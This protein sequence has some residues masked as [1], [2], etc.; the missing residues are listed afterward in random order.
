MSEQ[1]TDNAADS[2][3][4]ENASNTNTAAQS[5]PK[6]HVLLASASP[7]RR[8]LLKA[9]GVKFRVLLP[10]NGTDEQLEPD[11]IAMPIE[12]AKKLA[13]RKAAAA[14]QELLAANPA[15]DLYAVI[16]ADTM[17][18]HNNEI[19][20]K[21]RNLD[22]AKRMLAALSGNTHEVITGV[23][24]WGVAVAPDGNVS[25]FTRTFAEKSEVVFKELDDKQIADYL[26]KGESFDKAGAYAI[27]GEGAALV[28]ETRGSLNN[29][30]GLPTE[31]LLEVFPDLLNAV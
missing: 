15:A 27:Q 8:D 19:F 24:I 3:N 21:P 13:E 23:S 4:T 16:G 1:Q 2:S 29:I 20:G 9:A 17:V 5:A 26:R 14:V 7:R 30:I 28:Q 22:D 25:L 31:R 11:D 12:A 6:L 10:Q 18:V